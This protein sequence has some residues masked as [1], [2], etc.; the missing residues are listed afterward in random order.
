MKPVIGALAWIFT[1]TILIGAAPPTQ[2]SCYFTDWD[3]LTR[4]SQSADD[5]RSHPHTVF[6]LKSADEITAFLAILRIE[7]IKPTQDAGPEDAR[8]TIDIEAPDGLRTYYASRFSL[9]SSDSSRKRA[10]DATF[11]EAIR[12]YVARNSKRL[13]N[14]SLDTNAL[15][16]Q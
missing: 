14:Q 1:T 8:M 3:V 4:V 7:D 10:I 15:S 6:H 12:S 13:A 2:I 11:R 9:C 16:R 5:I